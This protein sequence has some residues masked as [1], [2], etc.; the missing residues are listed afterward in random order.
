MSVKRVIIIRT[1]ETDW[2]MQGRWQGWVAA[3]LN[4]HG[5]AQA[6]KLAQFVRNIG[7]KA[8]YSSDLRRASE[9]A[10]ILA[11]SLGYT[12]IYDERLRERNIGIW[13]GLTRKEFTAW[14]PD[15]YRALQADPDGYVIPNGESRQQVVARLMAAFQDIIAREDAETVGILT[16]TTAGRLLLA[17]LAP[18]VTQRETDLSNTSV[19]TLMRTD[20]GGWRV[21]AVNDVLHLE[22][23]KAEIFK[24]SEY[25]DDSRDR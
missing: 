13:Q 6:A 21:V 8:L 4:A 11:E 19:T 3:P 15:E 10:E 17:Q 1:G 18:D 22:G 9:T 20:G 24:E 16:H 14:Y 12:P 25:D 23:L 2:N 7:M 5:R